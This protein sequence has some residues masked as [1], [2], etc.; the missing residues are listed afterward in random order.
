MALALNPALRLYRRDLRLC[1]WEIAALC[2]ALLLWALWE[3]TR[4]E[5]VS[6]EHFASFQAARIASGL[7]PVLWLWLLW[8][9]SHS[10]PFTGDTAWWLTRPLSPRS[11]AFARLL[12]FLTIIALPKLLADLLALALAGIDL[13]ETA[14]LL[15]LRL[16]ALTLWALAV[17]GFASVTS[18]PRSMLLTLLA[19]AGAVVLA[20]SI[21]AA[22]SWRSVREVAWIGET[23]TLAA[24]GFAGAAALT[25]QLVCR[26]TLAAR[27][28]LSAGFALPLLAWPFY[29]PERLWDWQKRVLES[30]PLEQ[31]QLTLR[32]S[33]YRPGRVAGVPLGCV[34]SLTGVPP[35]TRA[36]F[37]V[38]TH[39]IAGQPPRNT[40]RV[41][42]ARAG[43]TVRLDAAIR[44][45]HA[46]PPVELSLGAPPRPVPGLGLCRAYMDP[47]PRLP[48][49]ACRSTAGPLQTIPSF[50]Y[51]EQG[52]EPAVASLEPQSWSPAP[53]ALQFSPL[54]TYRVQTRSRERNTTTVQFDRPAARLF[55]DA[56][57]VT[58]SPDP[59]PLHDT[60][61]RPAPT[62]PPPT[63]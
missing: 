55:R 53:A 15:A 63:P 26:H 27:A 39:Q 37:E 60:P 43:Q 49:L 28:L 56:T 31:I 16:G 46:G 3:G 24:W 6:A 29:T 14:G 33:Q 38:I 5:G 42:T 30:P 36:H 20:L 4:P 58:P 11:I 57:F 7:I 25:V 45:F 10:E 13:R 17:L 54:T 32:C 41:V 21:P 22:A 1:R 35:E 52:G 12:F 2:T 48:F 61:A 34:A 9:T 44:V 59:G 47:G 18:G 23:L 8:R 50:Y 62:P 51:F 19:A 40:G